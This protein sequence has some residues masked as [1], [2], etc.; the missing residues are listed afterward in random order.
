[1]GKVFRHQGGGK[2]GA[3]LAVAMAHAVPFMGAQTTLIQRVCL[4]HPLDTIL[5]QPVGM[6][7]SLIGMAR[8]IATSDPTLGSV[9]LAFL[10]CFFNVVQFLSS[11]RTDMKALFC[12]V[13]NLVIACVWIVA[14][15][16]PS[17]VGIVVWLPWTTNVIAVSLSK[18]LGYRVG[19]VWLQWAAQVIAV[20]VFVRICIQV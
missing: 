18:T 6:A 9:S 12:A 20:P 1:M 15:T 2:T 19:V 3:A 8:S 7:E 4:P 17:T 10:V 11:K 13:L 16:T 5:S 14:H